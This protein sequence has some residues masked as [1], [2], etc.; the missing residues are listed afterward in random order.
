LIPERVV[1]QAVHQWLDGMGDRAWTSLRD[2]TL[3]LLEEP[4]PLERARDLMNQLVR[5]GPEGFLEAEAAA[6]EVFSDEDKAMVIDNYM[7]LS[8]RERPGGRRP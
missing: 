8:Y 5:L 1:R 7:A 6:V 4:N 2:R 3:T